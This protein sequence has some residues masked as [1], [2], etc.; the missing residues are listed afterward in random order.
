MT[1]PYMVR[2]KK[3]FFKVA[4]PGILELITTWLVGAKVSG[5]K[6]AYSHKYHSKGHQWAKVSML[7]CAVQSI[8]AA[9][10]C[11]LTP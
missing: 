10:P 6:I 3:A 7:R 5:I 8:K 11:P 9:R 1:I 4:K 2:P